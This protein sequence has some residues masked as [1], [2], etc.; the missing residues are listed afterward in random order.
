MKI[1]GWI[2]LKLV[3]VLLKWLFVVWTSSFFLKRWFPQLHIFP[4]FSNFSVIWKKGDIFFIY[5]VMACFDGWLGCFSLQ[6]NDF[7]YE[8]ERE[9]KRGGIVKHVI[10]ILVWKKE[11]KKVSNNFFI[12]GVMVLT[13]RLCS[14]DLWQTLA[15][16]ENSPL[17]FC[18]TPR[19][20]SFSWKVERESSFTCIFFV[21]CKV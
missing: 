7:V 17:F 11:K 9:R 13:L 3:V 1:D 19:L 20:T 5:F 8:D 4:L 12:V 6:K 15:L 10:W 14:A 16:S 2:P 21:S 18:L